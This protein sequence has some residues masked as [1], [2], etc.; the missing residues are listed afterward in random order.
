MGGE[1][2]FRVVPT[3]GMGA[4]HMVVGRTGPVLALCLVALSTAGCA[5]LLL[6]CGDDGNDP[7][8]DPRE[9]ALLTR[10][11]RARDEVA[12]FE[13]SAHAQVK[14]TRSHAE[15][16]EKA[17]RVFDG[18]QVPKRIPDE[19]DEASIREVLSAAAA[20]A[21]LRL[22]DLSIAPRPRE[23]RSLP[24]EVATGA[25]FRYRPDDLR[26]ILEIRFS[27]A[28]PQIERLEALDR[29]LNGPELQ[30]FVMLTEA[31]ATPEGFEV[32]AQAMRF[33]PVT[34]PRLVAIAPE[35]TEVLASVGEELDELRDR[36]AVRRELEGLRADLAR[37]S[38]AA[39]E[40]NVALRPIPEANLTVA[41]TAILQ[42]A[43]STVEGR[44]LADILR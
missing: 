24:T 11:R 4:S 17:R 29:S 41:R 15:A 10:L 13:A 22:S 37:A 2:A 26:E 40:A 6:A 28:P 16:V 9:E 1:W 35:E 43:A 42:R 20:E 5:A 25:E 30:R 31:R 39:T 18:L 12:T 32:V 14:N 44:Q 36:P 19:P 21:R 7:P 27:A 33:L 34:P 38:A 3:T 8:P 23:A